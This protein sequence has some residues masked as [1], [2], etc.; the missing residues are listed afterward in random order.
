M[1]LLPSIRDSYTL[2]FPSSPDPET[3]VTLR[4]Y[5]QVLTDVNLDYCFTCEHTNSVI[6]TPKRKYTLLR[7]RIG[8]FSVSD[9]LSQI[10]MGT[11]SSRPVERLFEGRRVDKKVHFVLDNGLLFIVLKERQIPKEEWV[12]E[13]DTGKE[14]RCPLLNT[15]ETV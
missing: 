2:A 6:L 1:G 12:L 3:T 15:K 4:R 11:E 8:F 10:T 9:E 7:F 5:D 13:S 14:E